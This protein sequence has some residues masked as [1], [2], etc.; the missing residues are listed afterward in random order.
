MPRKP[1]VGRI[2]SIVVWSIL[3]IATAFVIDAYSLFPSSPSLPGLAILLALG[4]LLLLFVE[5]FLDYFSDASGR[6]FG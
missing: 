3:V 4:G 5:W 1:P 2:D 6:M